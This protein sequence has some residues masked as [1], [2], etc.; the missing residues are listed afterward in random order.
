MAK[1]LNSLQ[2]GLV[3]DL[4]ADRSETRVLPLDA[5]DPGCTRLKLTRQLRVGDSGRPHAALRELRFR[6]DCPFL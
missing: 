1:K 5:S 3:F 2:R 4:R 6:M